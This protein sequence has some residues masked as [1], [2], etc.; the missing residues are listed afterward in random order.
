MSA[1]ARIAKRGRTESEGS[2]AE[3]AGVQPGERLA[4]GERSE[5]GGRAQRGVGQS[6]RAGG[7]GPA[8]ELV[9]AAVDRARVR[10]AIGEL[11]GGGGLADEVID[12]LLAG[13]ST[14]EEIVGP[15]GLLAQLTKRLVE[16]ALEAELTEHLGYEPHA[17]PPGGTGNTRNGT[18][19]KDA[20]DR[21]WAGG[22][23]DAAR[24]QRQ[25]CAADRA[26]ATAALGRL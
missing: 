9:D 8:R 26:Q 6:L 22:D 21:A 13:A 1:R 24:S 16:R 25:L 4:G 18:T 10:S 14:E 11:P 19:A 23:P 2:G 3:L 7:R 20:A 17:E 12:E 5:P 15:G